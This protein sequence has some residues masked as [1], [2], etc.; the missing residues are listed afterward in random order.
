LSVS[1]VLEALETWASS[2]TFSGGDIMELSP[3]WDWGD[4][5]AQVAARAF[6]AIASARWPVVIDEAG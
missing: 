1:E 5:T 3:R 4:E 2:P 6:L